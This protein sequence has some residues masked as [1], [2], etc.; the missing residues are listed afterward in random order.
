MG[1]YQW[2][3]TG[4]ASDEEITF[5]VKLLAVRIA[6]AAAILSEA[7]TNGLGKLS[8]VRMRSEALSNRLKY[9]NENGAS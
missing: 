9:T 5:L 7:E 6:A 3:K 8:E 2:Y 4:T 1:E